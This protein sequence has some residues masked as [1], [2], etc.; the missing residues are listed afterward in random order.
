MTDLKIF[1]SGENINLCEPDEK[2]ASESDWFDWFNDPKNTK[3]LDQGEKINT[4][5]DQLNFF[6]S[7][8]NRIVL[9]IQDKKSKNYVGV[10]SLSNINN[11]KKTCEL[12][13]VRDLKKSKTSSPLSSLE[14]ISF[15]TEHA[16]E[17]MNMRIISAGQHI[18]LENWQN[19]MELAGY[20]LEGLHSKRFYKHD[21]ESD[22][23]SIACHVKDYRHL[24]K[25]RGKLWDGNQ[26]MFR[27]YKKLVRIEKF[28]KKFKKFFEK[29]KNKYYKKIFEL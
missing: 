11:K 7:I 21:N 4:Q 16:F 23:V 25:I 20:K 15:M 14:S 3:Y 2:F 10:V 22:S 17:N 24:K 19:Q 26:K 18:E 9:I 8:K 1:I 27:R 12:A 28:S 5:N 6:L 13:I 29:E